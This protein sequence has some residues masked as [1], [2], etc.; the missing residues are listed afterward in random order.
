MNSPLW[1][2]QESRLLLESRP[3]LPVAQHPCKHKLKVFA[4]QH[5]V[6]KPVDLSR[7]LGSQILPCYSLHFQSGLASEDIT[8]ALHTPTH[9][10][11]GPHIM[12]HTPII[13]LKSPIISEQLYPSE[14]RLSASDPPISLY[15]GLLWCWLDLRTRDKSVQVATT[16]WKTFHPK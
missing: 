14:Q 1:G 7:P 4:S 5:P 6:G 16:W 15:H 9:T 8:R 3:E 12:E 2:P 10:Q 13:V 11:S